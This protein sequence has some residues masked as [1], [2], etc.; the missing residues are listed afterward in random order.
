MHF[1][2]HP[3]PGSIHKNKEE[4][5]IVMNMAKCEKTLAPI[6]IFYRDSKLYTLPLADF[7]AKYE[8][9]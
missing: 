9:T 2:K 5:A 8:P 7:T 1:L 3:N 6:V 4:V